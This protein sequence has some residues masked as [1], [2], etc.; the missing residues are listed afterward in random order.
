MYEL[1]MY[2]YDIHLLHEDRNKNIGEISKNK[3]ITETN[4][5][6]R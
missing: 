6:C 4:E 2:A 1:Q 5:K 3:R